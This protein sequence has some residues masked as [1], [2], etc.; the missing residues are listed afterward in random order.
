MMKRMRW[1]VASAALLA[2]HGAL[3][4]SLADNVAIQLVGVGP[5]YDAMCGYKCM[6]ITFTATPSGSPCSFN[7]GWHYAINLTTEGGR[8]AAAVAI[9]AKTTGNLVQA[10]GNGTC[11]FSASRVEELAYMFMK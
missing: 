3:A 1:V 7:A 5:T 4:G 8:T 11:V 2:G 9:T 6:V 10:S